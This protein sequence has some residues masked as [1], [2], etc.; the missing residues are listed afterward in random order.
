VFILEE[1]LAHHLDT[2]RTRALANF[3][4]PVARRYT[5]NATAHTLYLKGRYAWNTRTQEGITEAIRCFEAAVAE[6]PAYAPAFAGLADSYALQLDYR[7]VPVAEGHRL[8]KEYALRAIALDES[9]AEAHSSLAWSTFLH[10]WDWAVAQQEFRRAIELNPAYA[11]ARQFHAFLLASQGRLDEALVEAH[12]AL[13]LDPASVSIRRAVGYVYLYARRYDQVR[14]H[15]TRALAMNPT[16]EE[17]I[18]QAPPRC[19]APRGGR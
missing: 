1:E 7:A 4:Q 16:A 19:R 13:E 2:L 12:S 11:T 5:K 10:D 17:S 6:D 14:Y 18:G 8:A 15:I 9:V 3:T